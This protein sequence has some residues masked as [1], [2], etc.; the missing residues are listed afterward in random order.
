MTKPHTF[1]LAAFLSATL[2]VFAQNDPIVDEGFVNGVKEI[3]FD[4]GRFPIIPIDAT[5]YDSAQR[6]IPDAVMKMAGL[7]LNTD[8]DATM[9][10]GIS[11][12]DRYRWGLSIERES[13][14]GDGI[15]DI[16]KIR[17]PGWSEHRPSSPVYYT[18]TEEGVAEATPVVDAQTVLPR[19]R[20]G[21]GISAHARGSRSRN[22][23]RILLRRRGRLT[24]QHINFEIMTRAPMRTGGGVEARCTHHEIGSIL[25]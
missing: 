1:T 21:R 20:R 19:Q 24:R 10:G 6:G 15:S 7:P 16:V 25:P 11:L 13:T 23:A 3:M 5:K 4:E 18:I 9:L 8:T 17:P 12:R 14:A 2:H 22:R